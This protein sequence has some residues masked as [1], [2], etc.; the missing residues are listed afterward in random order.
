MYEQY[1]KKYCCKVKDSKVLQISQ[2]KHTEQVL[3]LRNA[4]LHEKK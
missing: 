1:D 4:F 2:P 3:S